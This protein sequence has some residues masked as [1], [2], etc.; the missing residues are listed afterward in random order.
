ML[1]E[2]IFVFA[3][4]GLLFA[5][6][7][8]LIGWVFKILLLGRFRMDASWYSHNARF[9]RRELKTLTLTPMQRFLRFAYLSAVYS[10]TAGLTLGF[11]G[12][13]GLFLA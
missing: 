5:I 10:A 1:K 6:A 11:I 2:V 13:L 8:S 12:F 4:G 3:V 9:V 7:A